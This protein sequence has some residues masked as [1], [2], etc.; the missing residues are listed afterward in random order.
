[1]VPMISSQWSLFK[2]FNN[3]NLCSRYSLSCCERFQYL[4]AVG[5]LALAGF[6]IFFRIIPFL[7]KSL[8][9]KDRRRFFL[10]KAFI[11]WAWTTLLGGWFVYMVGF[12]DGG[13]ARSP[14]AIIVRSFLSSLEQFVFHS[15]L[16][17]VSE[18]CHGSQ[19]FMTAYTISYFSAVLISSVI[20]VN[21]LR[22]RITFFFRRLYWSVIHSHTV[23]VFFEINT[24]SICLAK[25][26]KAKESGRIVF[27]QFPKES[28]EHKGHNSL[29]KIFGLNAFN[30]QQ[31]LAIKGLKSI[32]MNA[33]SDLFDEDMTD[34]RC[35]SPY[36]LE[37]NGLDR[38]VKLLKDAHSIRLFFLSENENENVRAGINMANSHILIGK[39]V[40]IYCKARQ[41][42]ENYTLIDNST[43]ALFHLVDDSSFAVNSLKV[44][45]WDRTGT[46]VAHP[47]NYVK[48]N[49][50][51][52][53]V[54]SAFNCM[55][56]GFGQ[57]GQDAMRFLYE[58]GSFIDRTGRKSP[59][60]CR[61]IDKDMNSYLGY[62]ASE[63]PALQ[64]GNG[65][66]SD[67]HK[68][69]SSREIELKECDVHSD[70]F[71]DDLEQDDF[72]NKLNCIVVALGSDEENISLATKLYEFAL[73][74]DAIGNKER[75]C[76]KIFVRGYNSDEEARLRNVESFYRKENDVI[77]IFGEVSDIYTY[78]VI[79]KNKIQEQAKEFFKSYNCAIGETGDWALRRNKL[80]AGT[81]D[82]KVEVRIK[83][84][85][86]RY[87]A[88]HQFTK[89]QLLGIT[90]SVKRDIWLPSVYPF[91][92]DEQQNIN[93]Q[94]Y[95]GLSFPCNEDKELQLW[96][97]RL[98]NVSKC[99][100]LRWNSSMYML[101][102]VYVDAQKKDF[103]KRQ[104][105]Y[106][107]DWS[108]L[109]SVVRLYDYKVVE[110]TISLIQ[111]KSQSTSE[112]LSSHQPA[113]SLSAN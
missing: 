80:R 65:S 26:I 48:V 21:C 45:D 54:E 31:M 47:I 91:I 73:R 75:N 50:A 82:Q 3:I 70:I 24:K 62:I 56:V 102:F 111:H 16:I 94:C 51:L 66:T 97:T 53:V 78:D 11:S 68:P 113:S 95:D 1:M 106:L 105:K 100:H 52:G 10:N 7:A 63:I 103:R 83:E 14:I 64:I 101:G 13:T 5:L 12:C 46:P 32:V 60:H 39:D 89:L 25:S 22:N 69:I 6:T 59:F 90:S 41:S 84:K 72:I 44:M 99:E 57:T 79:I 93:M 8:A 108:Q 112:S 2:L 88:L 77:R 28:E 29:S 33:S 110:T 85:Q 49:S 43:N 35:V 30:K 4:V 20:V 42:Y 36:A 109:D 81:I 23:N 55:V 58:F 34:D 9:N 19:W 61:V 86:D 104:H 40:E 96:K 87:N 37:S 17:E 67:A 27:I 98:E 76:L 107:V 92:T 38:L 18:D 15:D 71:W 74:H